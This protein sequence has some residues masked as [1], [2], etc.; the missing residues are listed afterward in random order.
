[1]PREL[2][3]PEKSAAPPAVASATVKK[4]A[5][6]F[7]RNP[8]V[9]DAVLDELEHSGV[10]QVRQE[11]G[12]L[13]RELAVRDAIADH[14]LTRADAVFISGSTPEQ[15][16]ASAAAFKARMDLAASVVPAPGTGAPAEPAG[17]VIKVAA[18]GMVPA[19]IVPAAAPEV[20]LLPAHRRAKPTVE[21]AED[22]LFASM[23]GVKFEIPGMP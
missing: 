7:A 13:T 18:M 9:F 19:K 14:G 15:I 23:Q 17:E 21:Q 2:P 1:M 20:P 12:A 8:E 16:N 6:Y 11:V 3:N 22:D 5:A 10:V 4:Q